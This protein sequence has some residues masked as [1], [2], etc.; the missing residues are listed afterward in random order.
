V[1]GEGGEVGGKGGGGVGE[2]DW[3]RARAVLRN[4]VHTNH[5]VMGGPE[6]GPPVTAAGQL[7]AGEPQTKPE[8]RET[9]LDGTWARGAATLNRN[10]PLPRLKMC[11][12]K[13]PM[14]QPL[15]E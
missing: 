10:A 9:S 15:I 13:R 6:R 3:Q 12:T 14:T 11:D 1:T 4:A 8:T 5:T 7:G 2:R